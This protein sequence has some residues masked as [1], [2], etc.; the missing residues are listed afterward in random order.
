MYV[1]KLEDVE[2]YMSKFQKMDAV[3]KGGANERSSA[4]SS[5]SLPQTP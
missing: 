5:L 4:Q 1:Q 3:V 2:K